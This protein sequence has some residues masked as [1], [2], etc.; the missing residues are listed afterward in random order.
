MLWA[1]FSTKTKA[2]AKVEQNDFLRVLLFSDLFFIEFKIWSDIRGCFKG[3]K[4]NLEKCMHT[5][6]WVGVNQGSHTGL[7]VENR[8]FHSCFERDTFQGVYVGVSSVLF[9]S[10]AQPS[11][12]RVSDM[13]GLEFFPLLSS[14]CTFSDI[15]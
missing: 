8:K 7:C 9:V 15:M 2:S 14:G 4:R 1:G 12:S 11:L 10:T 13:V 6:R 5:F 3:E